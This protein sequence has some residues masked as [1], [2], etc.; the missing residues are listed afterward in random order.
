MRSWLVVI[1][2]LRRFYKACVHPIC[3]LFQSIILN[4]MYPRILSRCFNWAKSH[5]S[6]GAELEEESDKVPV[7]LRTW[8]RD[9]FR[10]V[11]VA[12]LDC[13]RSDPHQEVTALGRILHPLGPDVSVASISRGSTVLVEAFREYLVS[14]YL[15]IQFSTFGCLDGAYIRRL[16]VFSGVWTGSR[17]P[18]SSLVG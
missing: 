6:C 3:L 7:F 15:T 4:G 16:P 18:N 12:S 5:G 14:G 17:W 10:R 11:C 8:D 13:Y 1:L 9:T 2:W